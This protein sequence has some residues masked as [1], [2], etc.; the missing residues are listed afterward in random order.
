MKKAV[1]LVVEK[2]RSLSAKAAQA[3]AE[4]GFEVV[5]AA[6]AADGLEKIWETRPDLVIASTDLPPVNGENACLRLR[7]ASYLPL[8]AIGSR[9]EV[10]EMLELG[11]DACIIRPPS[12]RE[13]V[14]RVHLLLN[15]KRNDHTRGG[16]RM[17]IKNY[18]R[19]RDDPDGLSPTE[20]R[21]SSYFLFNEGKLLDYPRLITEVW[22]GKIKKFAANS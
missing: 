5:E 9:D 18:V 4:A 14:A 11:A 2:D 12:N 7:Q 22:G 16:G 3:L 13:V 6:D 10:V 17:G 15:R 19:A 20:Y 1:I 21:L 8:I